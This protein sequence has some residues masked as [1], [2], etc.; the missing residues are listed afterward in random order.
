VAAASIEVCPLAGRPEGFTQFA[1]VRRRARHARAPRGIGRAVDSG[2]RRLL[3]DGWLP[4]FG[5]RLRRARLL[6]RCEQQCVPDGQHSRQPPAKL[7][8]W[9][10]VSTSESGSIAYDYLDAEVRS[11]SG[12]PLGSLAQYTNVGATSPGIYSQKSFS[13]AGWRGQTVRVQLRVTTDSSLPTSFRI[14][15]LSLS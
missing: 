13:L 14:D 11:T 7:T 12:A 1:F 6:Q 3:V 4:A 5:Q 10:N 9:L 2:R 15:D 8:F